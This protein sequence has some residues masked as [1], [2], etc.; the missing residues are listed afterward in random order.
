MPFGIGLGLT[1]VQK[2]GGV[3]GDSCWWTCLLHRRACVLQSSFIVRNKTPKHKDQS[4]NSGVRGWQNLQSPHLCFAPFS[5]YALMNTASCFVSKNAHYLSYH[6]SLQIG[7]WS[8][9][10]I[11]HFH[12]PLL[13]PCLKISKGNW[14]IFTHNYSFNKYLWIAIY[15]GS[16]PYAWVKAVSNNA[17]SQGG[18][19]IGETQ[20]SQRTSG[21]CRPCSHAA[22]QAMQPWSPPIS[23][24]TMLESQ[25]RV[26][27]QD[28]VDFWG[29]LISRMG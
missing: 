9:W 24:F 5:W 29:A 2:K 17:E 12:R 13:F 19:L 20:Y 1:A 16:V 23:C 18:Y 25:W 4:G 8:S 26:G 21:Y 22:M 15:G 14:D 11:G 6:S 28:L 7:K 10:S 3:P 27:W